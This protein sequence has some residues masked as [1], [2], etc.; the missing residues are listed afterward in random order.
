MGEWDRTLEIDAP[1]DVC[2]QIKITD[3]PPTELC[4]GASIDFPTPLG[5]SG[6]VKGVFDIT[7]TKGEGVLKAVVKNGRKEVVSSA[8]AK[9]VSD[10]KLRIALP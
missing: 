5:G 10:Q 8:A 2:W 6:P 1:P 3:L 4:G 7:R 9:T